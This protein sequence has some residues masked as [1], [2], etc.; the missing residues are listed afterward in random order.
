MKFLHLFRLVGLLGLSEDFVGAQV[1]APLSAAST[2]TSSGASGGSGSYAPTFSADGRFLVF[3]SRANNL[4]TNDSNAIW[5]DVF[6]RHLVSGTTSLVSVNR[7]GIGGGDGNSFNPVISSN[8]QF[9]AFESAA[10]NLV[11]NDT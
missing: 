5:L 4:V 9:I 1:A 3:T 7:S 10:S 6:V 2:T 11:A 8:G